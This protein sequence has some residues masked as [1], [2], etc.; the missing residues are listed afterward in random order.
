MTLFGVKFLLLDLG[1]EDLVETIFDFRVG[2]VG[3]GLFSRCDSLIEPVDEAFKK[4][5]NASSADLALTFLIF[6]V[7]G[8]GE[9]SVVSFS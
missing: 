5:C 8:D 4:L 3:F 1:V 7:L 6:F 2:V 9:A